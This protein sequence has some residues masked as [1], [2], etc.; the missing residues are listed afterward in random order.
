LAVARTTI[1]ILRG[2]LRVVGAIGSSPVL[3]H[4]HAGTRVR[5]IHS[6][7]EHRVALSSQKSLRDKR[8]EVP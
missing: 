2:G 5:T 1:A 4:R 3:S 7:D 6:K 8:L